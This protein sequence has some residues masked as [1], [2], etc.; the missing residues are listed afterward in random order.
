MASSGG[1]SAFWQIRH[2][3]TMRAFGDI[4]YV[5]NSATPK[6]TDVGMGGRA[7]LHL[8]KIDVTPTLVWW[9]RERGQSLTNDVRAILRLRR[10]F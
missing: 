8:G 1:V 9:R 7:T 4:R 6:Q 5:D 3:W 10:D 2:N